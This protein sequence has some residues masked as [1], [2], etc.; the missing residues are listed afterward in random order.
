MR[1]SH[2]KLYLTKKH[3]NMSWV[4]YRPLI[5]KL[6]A[7]GYGD[8]DLFCAKRAAAVRLKDSEVVGEKEDWPLASEA[9]YVI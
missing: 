4:V 1:N 6:A 9:R 7:D 2:R 5:K 3:L 8:Y